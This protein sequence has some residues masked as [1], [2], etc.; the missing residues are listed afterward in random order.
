M[1]GLAHDG[2][3]WKLIFILAEDRSEDREEIDDVAVEFEA[4]QEKSIRYE[5]EVSVTKE[6]ITW[7]SQSVRIVYRR[8]EA[9]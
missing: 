9:L 2:N 3:L 8:R 5:V 4:L 1:V 7:P 6:P